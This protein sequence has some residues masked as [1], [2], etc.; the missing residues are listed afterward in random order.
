LIDWC[1]TQ[2]CFSLENKIT[3]NQLKIAETIY[4][5]VQMLYFGPVLTVQQLQAISIQR[6]IANN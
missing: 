3:E 4:T 1:L 5:P 2:G 6:K